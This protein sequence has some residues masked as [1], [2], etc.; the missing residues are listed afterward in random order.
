MNFLIRLGLLC[1]GLG[2]LKIRWN[3]NNWMNQF[4]F[5]L[6]YWMKQFKGYL[7]KIPPLIFI[8]FSVD[9]PHY[10]HIRYVCRYSGKKLTLISNFILGSLLM[11]FRIFINRG[12]SLEKSTIGRILRFFTSNDLK[13]KFSSSLSNRNLPRFT[14]TRFKKI[15]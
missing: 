11:D 6:N 12:N 10:F 9:F 7:M 13:G 2:I 4:F 15:K 8:S 3:L 1:S 14:G 5:F